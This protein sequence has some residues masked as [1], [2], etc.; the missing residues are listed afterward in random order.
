MHVLFTSRW[1][2]RLSRWMGYVYN[3]FDIIRR[4]LIDTYSKF[5]IKLRKLHVL[6]TTLQ[7]ITGGDGEAMVWH[8][9]KNKLWLGHKLWH[10]CDNGF[11]F[12][13]QA[14]TDTADM[15]DT[16]SLIIN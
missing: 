7:A 13:L 6:F 8:F 14:G 12:K 10:S 5:L 3:F 4:T 11:S 15:A 16:V 2:G 1:L 9:L